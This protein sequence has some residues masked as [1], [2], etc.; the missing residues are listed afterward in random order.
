[1]TRHLRLSRLFALFC[2]SAAR[3]ASAQN[4]TPGD[5]GIPPQGYNTIGIEVL[6]GALLSDTNTA[7][8]NWSNACAGDPGN[9]F[10]AIVTS[11]PADIY[12]ELEF[13]DAMA[14]ANCGENAYTVSGGVL[15]TF[16][17]KIWSTDSSGFPCTPYADAIT[18]E[19]GHVYGLANAE[20]PGGAC[21]GTIMGSRAIGGTREITSA[22]CDVANAKD[23][24][25]F[26]WDLDH[27]P[28]PYCDGSCP[29]PCEHGVCPESPIIIDLDGRGA[30][31]SGLDDPVQFDI[32]ASGSRDTIG[33]TARG[34]RT[35]FLCL[36]LNTNG[37]IDSG[38]ELFGTE[39]RWPYSG[40]RT[41][42][43][44]VALSMYDHASLG[45]NNNGHID[46]G[47]FW[48]PAL[49]VWID[50]NH[51]GISQPAELLSLDEAGIVDIE[52]AY[53]ESRRVD[54]Y[55]N[56]FRY[57]GRARIRDRSGNLHD[58]AIYDVFFVRQ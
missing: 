19:I 32:S 13:I 58:R 41:L 30:E 37:Q 12:G 52:L 45:G 51:D 46:K 26:E 40:Q 35:A 57:R 36:D 16:Y 43:G 20:D 14:P 54:R 50:S 34:S 5:D 15:Q 3:L 2:L 28:P 31:L 39:T 44:F 53:S 55:G 7:I 49:R 9:Y 6:G 10:A 23:Y 27:P 21:F 47:D 48:F 25:S 33:W 8:N 42:N 29:V 4:C 22:A 11:G 17:I 56:V 1:M 38:R 24:T 18:H